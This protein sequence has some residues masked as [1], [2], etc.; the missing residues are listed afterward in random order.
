[1]ALRWRICVVVAMT[2]PRCRGSLWPHTIGMG[3]GPD[4]PGCDVKTMCFCPFL[5]GGINVCSFVLSPQ[6]SKRSVPCAL[7][8]ASF[9]AYEDIITSRISPGAGRDEGR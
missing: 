9:H 4:V 1:M 5:F 7:S 8:P 6:L 3:R 2:G